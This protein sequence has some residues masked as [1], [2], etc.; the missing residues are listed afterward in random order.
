MMEWKEIL[1][2]TDNDAL[3]AVSNLLNEKGANGVIIEDPLELTK[4]KPNRFGEIYDL[5]MDKYPR[6]GIYIKGYFPNNVNFESLFNEIKQEV[7]ALEDFGINLGEAKFKTNSFKEEDWAHSWKKYYKPTRISEKIV[8]IPEWEQTY[9]AKPN[10]ILLKLDPGMAFGTGTHPTTQ[11]SVRALEQ[12]IQNGD[13]VID[14]GCGSGVLSIAAGLLGAKEIFAYDLDEV[15]VSSTK[16]N[17]ALNNQANAINV[18]QNNLLENIHH[19]ADIIVANILAEIIVKMIPDAKNLLES[20]GKLILSGIIKKNE[21]IVRTAL[22]ENKFDIV[23]I[24]YDK[25]WVMMIAQKK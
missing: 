6:E 20:E 10:D 1:I 4:K 15:A 12:V 7:L 18:K 5:N 16:L 22:S 13:R 2:H 3:E 8:V 23:E 25:E 14:V 17:A 9:E 19:K 21:E 24:K 11:L